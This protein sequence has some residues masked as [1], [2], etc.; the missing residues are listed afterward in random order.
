MGHGGIGGER[1]VSW[2]LTMKDLILTLPPCHV[3]QV[4]F[5]SVLHLL[6]E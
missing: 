2:N 6:I 1:R 3:A 4:R 5:L